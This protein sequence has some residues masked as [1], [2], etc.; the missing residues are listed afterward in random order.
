MKYPHRQVRYMPFYRV[1]DTLSISGPGAEW[2]LINSRLPK[3]DSLQSAHLEPFLQKGL[4]RPPWESN[5]QSVFGFGARL[6]AKE[7][8]NRLLR[9]LIN[10]LL[11][12][13]DNSS[14]H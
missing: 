11:I 3:P 8:P 14:D 13:L 1:R 7:K 10:K 6:G 12:R 2:P 5:H 9:L 4:L